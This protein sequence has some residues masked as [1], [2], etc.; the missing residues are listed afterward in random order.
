M[1]IKPSMVYLNMDYIFSLYIHTS[2]HILLIKVRQIHSRLSSCNEN[3]E[4]LCNS[5]DY[6]TVKKYENGILILKFLYNLNS[7]SLLKTINYLLTQI[8]YTVVCYK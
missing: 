8:N 2:P 3:N 6:A 4:S 5:Y 1:T 7:L